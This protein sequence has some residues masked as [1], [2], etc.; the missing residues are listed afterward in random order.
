MKRVN[1]KVLA[2]NKMMRESNLQVLAENKLIKDTNLRL[3]VQIDDLKTD[4]AEMLALRAANEKLQ[5]QMDR[6]NDLLAGVE[7]V[8]AK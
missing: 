6:I 4:K 5:A 2:E 1:L 7:L 3:Q 8:A